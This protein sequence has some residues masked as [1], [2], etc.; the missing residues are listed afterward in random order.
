MVAK[1]ILISLTS[2]LTFL[3]KYNNTPKVTLIPRKMFWIKT[4]V[5]HKVFNLNLIHFIICLEIPK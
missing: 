2:G 3:R 1:D 5:Y 4:K